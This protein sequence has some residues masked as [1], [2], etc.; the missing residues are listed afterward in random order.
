MGLNSLTGLGANNPVH[1]KPGAVDVQRALQYLPGV[2]A[3]GI[4]VVVPQ[5]ELNAWMGVRTN[6]GA[7]RGGIVQDVLKAALPGF[8]PLSGVQQGLEAVEYG[9]FNAIANA[10]NLPLAALVGGRETRD[11][12][13]GRTGHAA[14]FKAEDG[15][16]HVSFCS[17]HSYKLFLLEV[18]RT[19]KKNFTVELF[20]KWKR[21]NLHR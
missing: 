10:A 20:P 2:P 18:V 5:E 21:F 14:V 12:Q 13:G 19:G 3:S 16:G 11:A 15:R 17:V 1:R 4:E 7:D 9:G 6:P 8:F